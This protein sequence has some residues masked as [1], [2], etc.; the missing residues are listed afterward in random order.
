M[1]Q[2]QRRTL[3]LF[4]LF[5]GLLFVFTLW[6][7]C[8]IFSMPHSFGSLIIQPGSNMVPSQWLLPKGAFPM[9]H[10]DCF[11]KECA[12][13]GLILVFSETYNCEVLNP[14]SVLYTMTYTSS[15]LHS[16]NTF[17]LLWSLFYH[18]FLIS[19]LSTLY[20]DWTRT[21]SWLGL[22]YGLHLIF[23]FRRKWETDRKICLSFPNPS[24]GLEEMF[25]WMKNNLMKFSLSNTEMR[26]RALETSHW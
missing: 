26:R 19:W 14:G 10:R 5:L 25:S 6:E 17:R 20:R 8:V 24:L 12:H 21:V 15:N 4:D 2:V 23:P 9:A 22:H 18:S 1:R 3:I 7:K 11:P 13:P 16:T